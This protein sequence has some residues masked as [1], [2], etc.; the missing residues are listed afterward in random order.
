M[1][2]CTFE[3]ST[4]LGRNSRVGAFKDGRIID[5]NSATAWYLAQQGEAE[6][7]QLADGLAPPTMLAFL[8]A[9]L[10]AMHTAEELFL[11]AGP[12]PAD[13]WTL[14]CAPKGPNDET[15]VYT[16]DQVKLLAPLP[17]P[18]H[19]GTD[20]YAVLA[21]SIAPELKL[22]AVIGRRGMGI[23]STEASGYIAGFTAMIVI[24]PRYS[25]LG[26][27]LVTPDEMVK[28]PALE[29]IVRINSAEFARNSSGGLRSQISNKIGEL[30]AHNVIVPGD[31]VAVSVGV[32]PPVQPGDVIELEIETIGT[33]RTHAV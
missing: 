5:I 26:P 9:G 28:T 22:A 14:P 23:R 11:G 13:W 20:E 18:D 19:R 2:L 27:L 1:R 12:N 10:R 21:D 6:P 15:L 8:H 32:E 30:S 4:H 3:V 17:D 7:Q 25:T 29:V 24:G 33:L 16:P 31:V